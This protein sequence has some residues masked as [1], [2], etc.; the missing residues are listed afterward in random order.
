MKKLI[1]FTDSTPVKKSFA[2]VDSSRS[3][4]LQFLPVSDLRRAVK[5]ETD[6]ELFLYDSAS[7]T[8]D[9]KQKDLNYIQRKNGAAK[10]IIDRKNE[11][12]DPAGIIMKGTDYF[13]GSMMKEGIKPERLNKSIAFYKSSALENADLPEAVQQTGKTA[14]K[15]APKYIPPDGGWHGVKSGHDYTFFML[16]AEISIP[17]GWKKKSGSVH[18]NKLKETFQ[19]VVER[20]SAAGDGKVWIWNEYGGLVLFPYGG[21]SSDAILPAVKLML[22]RVMISVEDFQLHTPIKLRAAMH[23]GTTKYK[24]RGKTG[25]I[26]SDS[27]NSIFHLGTKFTPLDDFD[28]TEAVYDVVPER[29]QKLFSEAGSFEDRNIFR[30]RHF[31]VKG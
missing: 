12:I 25:T 16:F 28:I 23:L 9:S 10:G 21:N 2:A 15:P 4:N 17:T 24:V 31:E 7:A 26:I 3:W 30:L 22:N 19:S 20:E 14:R 11:I 8:D 18:L 1:V 13:S 29:V 27:I 5:E 6:T